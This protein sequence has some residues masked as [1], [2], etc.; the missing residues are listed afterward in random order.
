MFVCFC[1]RWMRCNNTEKQKCTETHFKVQLNCLPSLLLPLMHAYWFRKWVADW[2][3]TEWPHVYWAHKSTGLQVLGLL[4]GGQA[5]VIHHT[6]LLSLL[7]A[8]WFWSWSKENATPWFH[9]AGEGG[10]CSWHYFRILQ[11]QF[12]YFLTNS[13]LMWYWF[14]L[15]SLT[16]RINVRKC[17]EVVIA[18]C[19]RLLRLY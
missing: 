11:Q 18:S 7:A 14:N 16:F 15:I 10:Q 12:K 2:F 8:E 17:R 9:D 13:K 6:P 19:N 5:T 4:T 1:H 3:G